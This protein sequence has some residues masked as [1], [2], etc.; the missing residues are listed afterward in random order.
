MSALPPDDIKGFGKAVRISAAHTFASYTTRLQAGDP[1]Y[2]IAQAR[3]KAISLAAHGIILLAFVLL[4][5]WCGHVIGMAIMVP[6]GSVAQVAEL[7]FAV[8]LSFLGAFAF[9]RLGQTAL[10]ALF[11][12][13][14][15]MEWPRQDI[16]WGK[17]AFVLDRDGIAVAHRLVRRT[18][19]WDS[20]AE[21]TEDDVFVI[22]RKSGSEII[23]PKNPTDED[24]LRERLMRGITLSDPVPRD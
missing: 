14:E 6:L 12:I 11:D 9:M 22:Q 13:D 15:V 24:D 4:S 5:G 2:V 20:M 17:Q 19:R 8:L 10:R 7:F 3:I 1:D 23:I 21:L 16:D 18:Y